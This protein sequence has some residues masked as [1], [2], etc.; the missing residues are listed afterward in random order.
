MLDIELVVP[1]YMTS[2]FFVFFL[3]PSEV[4]VKRKSWAWQTFKAT[5]SIVASQY[6]SINFTFFYHISTLLVEPWGWEYLK[7]TILAV[8]LKY[9]SIN[10]SF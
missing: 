2:L 7:A 5:I 10:F 1:G 9:L 6:L 3:T 8:A 4:K